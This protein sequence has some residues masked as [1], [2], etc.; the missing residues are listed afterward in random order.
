MGRVSK[1][2]TFRYGF[3]YYN[4]Y[5]LLKIRKK[6]HSSNQAKIINTIR[7]NNGPT[8]QEIFESMEKDRIE[9]LENTSNELKNGDFISKRTIQRHLHSLIENRQIRKNHGRYFLTNEIKSNPVYFQNHTEK[10]VNHLLQQIKS[11]PKN[12][13]MSELIRNIGTAVIFIF[14]DYI[15]SVNSKEDVHWGEVIPI[16]SIFKH[17]ISLY[18]VDENNIDDNLKHMERDLE[19]SSPEIYKNLNYIKDKI[20]ETN[21]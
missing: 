19:T 13:Q 21:S 14:L 15:K 5:H 11:N 1:E 18:G 17:F 10:I 16:N 3:Q 6:I 7:K 20:R 2:F 12:I 8:S 9:I 4:V